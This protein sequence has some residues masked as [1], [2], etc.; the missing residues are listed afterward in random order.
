[1][2]NRLSNVTN[3][4]VVQVLQRRL[5]SSLLR[6]SSQIQAAIDKARAEERTIAR[7]SAAVAEEVH[8]NGHSPPPIPVL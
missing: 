8:Q 6:Q 4:S 1:M 3:V 7:M 2:F 5:S